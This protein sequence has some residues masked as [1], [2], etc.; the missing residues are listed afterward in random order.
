[1]QHYAYDLPL[2]EVGMGPR[3]RVASHDQAD[4]HF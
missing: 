1:M 2:E 3:E 4:E